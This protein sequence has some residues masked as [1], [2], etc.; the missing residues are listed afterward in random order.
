MKPSVIGHPH[1]DPLF[2]I[3]KESG[4][5]LSIDFLIPIVPKLQ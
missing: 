5:E 1:K 3:K 2:L 4:V